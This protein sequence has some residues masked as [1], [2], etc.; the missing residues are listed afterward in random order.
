MG[1]VVVAA[2]SRFV[3]DNGKWR[4]ERVSKVAYMCAGAFD[5]LAIGFDQRIGLARQRSDLDRK[6]SLEALGAPGA[7]GSK[8]FGNARQRRETKPHLQSSGQEE[9]HRQARKG[10]DDGAIEAVGFVVDF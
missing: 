7:N 2:G 8:A 3:D 6:F 5:D 10:N 9:R 1:K 4:F